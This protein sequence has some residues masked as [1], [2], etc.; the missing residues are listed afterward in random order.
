MITTETG[1]LE[2]L[3]ASGIP[4]TRIEHPPVYT[5]AEAAQYRAGA[6]QQGL[7]T[8]VVETKNLFLRAEARAGVERQFY[9]VMTACEK[10]LD[11]KALGQSIGAAKLHFATEAQ[12][13][14]A[15]GLTPGSVT[16]LAL[17]NDAARRVSLLVDQVYWPAQAYLCHPLVNT[18]TLVIEHESLVRF[19]ALT[20]HEPR[21]LTMP[22]PG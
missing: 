18:A 3:D 16:V 9:L 12:L 14:D 11:L 20:G 8:Q 1:L 13:M 7:E 4:Y 21:A 2:Y 6:A 17:V 19:F 22:G 10:R 15:L 5:C